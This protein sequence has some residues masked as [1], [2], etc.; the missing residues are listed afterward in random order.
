MSHGVRLTRSLALIRLRRR[1]EHESFPRI[2]MGL[3]VALTGSAGLL[4]S[5]T[6]LHAGV[7]SMALRY[8][9]ALVGAYV[10]FLFLLWLWLRTQ[11][12]DYLDLPDLPNLVP[13]PAASDPSITFSSG[14]G[15][16]F[17][18]G[19]ASSSF[20]GAGTSSFSS[21]DATPSIGDAAASSFDMDELAIPIIAAVLAIGLAF[22][23]LYVIYLAPAL[24][25]ELLFDGALSYSL[26]RHLRTADDGHWLSTAFRRTALPFALTAVFLVAVGAAMAAY[27]PGAH[28]IGEVIHH[29][30]TGR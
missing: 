19:G 16:D 21:T 5:F 3:V 20:D 28:S 13:N 1:L 26:Y 22:A 29:V 18:G 17:G 15:G 11:A 9:L 6:L 14:G 25:A 12:D 8:P 24:F 10:F 23:S 4:S 30:G 27:A 2:Q 7:E